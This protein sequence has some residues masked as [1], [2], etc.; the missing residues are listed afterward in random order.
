[1]RTCL[2][3]VAVL[4]LT[5]G[6]KKNKETGEKTA[7]QPA[8]STVAASGSGSTGSAAS[9]SGSAALPPADASVSADAAGQAAPPGAPAP[10]DADTILTTEAIGPL[11]IG[12]TDAAATKV[13]GRTKQ[14]TPSQ[15]EGATGEFASDWSWPGVTLGM[16]G[17]KRTGPVKVRSITVE[18]PSTYATRRGIKIGSSLAEV[19]RAYPKSDEGSDDPTLFLVGSPYGG[20]LFETKADVVVK[21]FLGAMVY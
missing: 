1:M 13:L 9:G 17:D 16:A 14:T 6:C 18:A 21:I 3:L 12:M 19:G 11:T 4:V 5:P 7:T 2:V 20:L 10:I 15:E 8:G